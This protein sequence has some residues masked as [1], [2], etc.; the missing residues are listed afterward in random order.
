[1][2]DLE[3]PPSA[4][5]AATA[6]L[7][8]PVTSVRFVDARR[9]EALERL[10]ITTVRDLLSH[11]PFRYLDLS[12]TADLHS[13]K[14]GCEATVTGRVHE[15]KV[16]RPRP[17][18]TI[19][20]IAIV[21]GTG[22]LVG[23]WFNQPYIAQRVKVGDRVALAGPVTFDF[24][25]KQIRSPFMEVLSDEGDGPTIARILPIHRVTEGLSTNWMRRLVTEALREAHGVL[26]P[27][28]ARIRS[29]RA[30][31]PLGTALAGIH[32][33][34]SMEEAERARR[35]LAYDELLGIELVVANRRHRTTGVPRGHVHVIDGPALRRLRDAIPYGLT[36]DQVKAVSDILHDM[37]SPHR[38]N[39]MLLGD[40]GTGK[41][42]VAAH[43]LAVCADSGTQAAMMAPTEV[44]AAQYAS[45]VGPL[46]DSAGVAWATLTG[47]TSAGERTR[48]LSGLGD[49]SIAAVFGTHALIDKAVRYERLSLAI[50]DE[51]HRFGVEQRL[52]LREKGDHLDLLVMTATPIPRSLALTVY[53]DLDASYL[54]ERPGS[55]GADH[56]TT[57]LVPRNRRAEAYD[58]VRAA[59]AAGEQ[60]Y[61]VCA[62]VDESDQSEL[63]AAN[64]EARRLAHQVFPQLKVGLL[65]GQM[66][67]RDKARVMEQFRAGALD[68]LVATTV[69]E[70]GVDVPRA[71][72]M[73]IEDAERFGL[74]QLHQ[75][76]GRV[77][78]GERP[79]QVLLFSDA[80]TESGRA[81][82]EAI[83]NVNDGFELAEFDLRLRGEGDVLGD[84]Q[85]G[86]PGLRAASLGADQDLLE[87]ACDDARRIIAEDADLVTPRYR[88]LA[89]SLERQVGS[90]W[91]WTSSG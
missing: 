79:G 10:D 55:R 76:R 86:I 74:A 71:T 53:G 75:L 82:M 49:G 63:K 61:V 2:S 89:E 81:R 73:I 51:Q 85:S 52:R 45:A 1:M 84:R 65:T 91:R 54:R 11:Y 88:P 18:L 47:S 4:R 59:V 44:L 19:T 35:R 7:A 42:V 37:R 8:S 34:G 64:A 78:R 30:L 50:V 39:R 38:M 28:P 46:L 5:A 87:M 26:D 20:E 66:P 9:A 60:A 29:E 77:G 22:A 67:S 17:R 90:A 72:I 23:V 15:V 16:K 27:L 41:T 14:A 6:R 43:A 3:T 31:P 58:I 21:D 68:V 12:H 62:L 83:V 13:V 70:V 32:F 69:I 57:R 36:Q 80:K 40:V 24:G 48:I 56:I 25:L 33:P